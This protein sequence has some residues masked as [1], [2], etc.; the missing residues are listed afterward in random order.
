MAAH[1]SG[2]PLYVLKA[3]AL[4]HPDDPHVLDNEDAWQRVVPDRL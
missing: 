2:V 4:A 3:L 1:A